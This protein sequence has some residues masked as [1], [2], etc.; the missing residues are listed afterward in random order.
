MRV[1][2]SYK[3][4]GLHSSTLHT[5]W[6]IHR[7]G[8]NTRKEAHDGFDAPWMTCVPQSFQ[9]DD[10][11]CLI[12]FPQAFQGHIQQRLVHVKIVH[13]EFSQIIIRM[14]YSLIFTFTVI[15]LFDYL[16]C[17]YW[18]RCIVGTVLVHQR[19]IG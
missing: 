9:G 8:S 19:A 7:G 11:V 3:S 5:R 16:N 14:T 1:S 6:Q 15:S 17:I 18:T 2:G 13:N 4:Q 10:H 12:A